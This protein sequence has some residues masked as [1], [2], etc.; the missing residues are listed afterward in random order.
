MHC[1][2]KRPTR[3]QLFSALTET[4]VNSELDTDGESGE[5]ESSG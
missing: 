5:S 3:R 4:H 1:N 2:L